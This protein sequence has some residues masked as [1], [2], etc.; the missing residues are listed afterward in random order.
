MDTKRVVKPPIRFG[1]FITLPN[2]R[3]QRELNKAKRQQE[4]LGASD[5]LLNLSAEPPVFDDTDINELKRIMYEAMDLYQDAD[6]IYD[7]QSSSD[8]QIER[9]KGIKDAE[10]G[11]L[12]D[13]A[14]IIYK[15]RFGQI[16]KD[17]K[18]I[19]E[20]FTNRIKNTKACND[21]IGNFK[22]TK[23]NCWICGFPMLMTTD[24]TKRGFSAQ[25][26][27][28]FPIAQ[29]V[30]FADLYNK[31]N[32]DDPVVKAEYRWAHKV[33]NAVKTDTHFVRVKGEGVSREWYISE[34]AI[35]DFLDSLYKKSHVYFKQAPNLLKDAISKN[36]G[37]REKDVSEW[38]K[39]RTIEI[40][41]V[42]DNVLRSRMSVSTDICDGPRWNSS[43]Y[44]LY[45]C[46][47]LINRRTDNPNPRRT[48]LPGEETKRGKTKRKSSPKIPDAKRQR[49]GETKRTRPTQ[50]RIH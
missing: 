29:A 16:T 40:K 36:Y 2:V 22:K 15:K 31:S 9:Y 25:C 42:S 49:A 13:M 21:V 8:E 5:S 18:N 46:A 17:W 33:C 23:D 10:L 4:R 39:K 19:R 45:R 28:V 47:E 50:K 20:F 32:K 43:L 34:D 41:K 11:K 1:E 26:E 37:N 44:M 30:F 7:S 6:S 48:P 27:H 12:S 38:I 3:Q 35:N 24:P 14:R